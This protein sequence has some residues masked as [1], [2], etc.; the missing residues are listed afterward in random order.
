M[1][2]GALCG[3]AVAATVV[4]GFASAGGITLTSGPTIPDCAGQAVA[5]SLMTLSCADGNYGLAGMKWQNWGAA[6]TRGSGTARANDCTPNCAAGKIQNFPV[7]ATTSAIR[8]CRSGR[9]QYTQLVLNY[10]GSRPAGLGAT[11]TWKFPCDAPGPGPTVTTKTAAK[12]ELTLTGAA[13]EQG[14]GCSRVDVGF[15]DKTTSFASAKVGANN[16][17]K[18]TLVDVRAGAVIVARQTCTSAA[19]GPRLYESAIDVKS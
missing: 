14:I 16:G 19:I 13:W 3:V 5:P 6:T 17:F 10:S 4:T 11:D 7:V 8:T 1:R 15:A 12:N 18:L 2:I 9:K